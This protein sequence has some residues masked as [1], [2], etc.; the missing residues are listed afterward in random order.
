MDILFPVDPLF[1]LQ[2]ALV[3]KP[4]NIQEIMLRVSLSKFIISFNEKGLRHVVSTSQG[5]TRK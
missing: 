5:P 1:I 4:G 3:S 2:G